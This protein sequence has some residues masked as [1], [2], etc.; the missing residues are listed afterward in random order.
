MSKK[1]L[2]KDIE[3]KIKKEAEKKLNILKKNNI[4]PKLAIIGMGTNPDDLSYK[5][6]LQRYGENLGIEVKDVSLSE[7]IKT[8]ELIEE[9]KTL[10]NN[11]D[12]SGILVLRPFPDQINESEVALSIDPHK[13]VDCMHPMNLAKV[14][15]GY[16]STFK[17][18]TA[19]A[20]LR[21][22]KHNGIKIEGK[23]IAIVNRT[24]VI[25]KALAMMLLK[26][27][28]TVI[29]C[30]S[31]TKD[32]KSITR[33]AD[34]VVTAIGNPNMLDKEYFKDDAI[35]ID[36]GISFTKDGKISGDVDFEDV[37]DKVKKITPVPGGVGRITTS[38]L[39]EQM[40]DSDLK[41]I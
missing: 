15:S 5:R 29:I 27:D 24:V 41:R 35:V 37:Y 10:N 18:C 16:S 39:Y 32:L 38:I 7:N 23:N 33:K 14:F 11:E 19:E 6:S 31:K 22:L 17:P 4:N 36:A 30:H 2:G 28:G 20:A 25:G 26:E 12:I 3:T 8:N 9:I 40:L 13:D 21:V 1:L 34:I